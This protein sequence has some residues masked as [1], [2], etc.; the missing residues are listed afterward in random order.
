MQTLVTTR[1]KYVHA[2]GI[3]ISPH[4]SSIAVLITT[5]EKTPFQFFKKSN[6]IGK[7]LPNYDEVWNQNL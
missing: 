7:K 6:L 1:T 4:D 5:A 2:F 3:K